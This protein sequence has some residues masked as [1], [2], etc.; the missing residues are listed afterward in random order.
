MWVTQNVLCT[1]EGDTGG[2]YKYVCLLFRL[3]LNILDATAP[4]QFISGT[5]SQA[6]PLVNY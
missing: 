1:T 2:S 5:D 4:W 3:K 6:F